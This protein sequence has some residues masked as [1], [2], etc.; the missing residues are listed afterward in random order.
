MNSDDAAWILT[1]AF[2]ILTMQSGVL[3]NCLKK[4]LAKILGFALLETGCVSSKNV[5][6]IM[7][8]NSIDVTVGGFA[9]WMF[10]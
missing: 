1:N 6:N 10:G 2:L 3:A 7:I 4:N 8:K 9:Y 5:A